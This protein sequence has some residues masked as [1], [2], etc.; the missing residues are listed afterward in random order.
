MTAA[1]FFED[2]PYTPDRFQLLAAEAIESGESVVVTAP[3]GAGKTLVAEVAVFLATQAGGRAFYTTPIKALSNQKY[4]EFG[5][6]YGADNV[7]LLTGDN[8]INGDAPIVVMTTE[9]LR[10]MIYS[11][12]RSLDDLSTVILDEVHYLADRFRGSVWEEVIIHAPPKVQL[13]CLSATVANPEE[14][15]EWIQARRG[16]TRLIIETH[17]PVPLEPM[18][19]V[20]D[21]WA[22]PKNLIYPMFTQKGSVR[23]A[24]EQVRRLL[25]AKTGKRRRFATPRRPDVVDRLRS[26]G[27]LPA[28]YFIFSRAGCESAARLVAGAHLRLTDPEE[29][30]VIRRIATDKTRHL[31]DADLA[32]LEFG[33]WLADLEGGV[34]A[35]HAG[36]VPAFKEVVEELFGMGLIKVVFATETLALG[37]NMPARTVVLDSLSKFN[38]ESHEL[39]GASDYTQLTGRAGRRGI[40]T[41]GYGVTLYSRFTR[42]E[43]MTEIAA[44]GSTRLDSSFRPTYNMAVNLVANYEQERAEELLRASFAEFQLLRIAAAKQQRRNELAEDLAE[45]QTGAECDRGD[46][47]EYVSVLDAGEVR[48]GLLEEIRP[49][50]VLAVKSGGKQGRYLM[51]QRRPQ[52]EAPIVMLSTAGKL[53]QFKVEELAGA[54]RQGRIEVSGAYRPSDRKFQQ[55]LVQRLRGFRQTGEETLA[56]LIDHP[57]AACPDAPTRVRLFRKAAKLDRRLKAGRSGA[58]GLVDQFRAILALLEKKGYVSGWHLLAPGE[59]LRRIYSESDLLVSEALRAGLLEG[60]APAE[61][62]AL[63]SGFVYE[64][65]TEATAPPL[66]R[67]LVER[68]AEVDDLWAALA[69]DEVAAGLHVSRRPDF[70]FAEIAYHWCQSIDLDEIL[71]ETPMAAGDFVRVARQLLD[72]LR[73]IRDAEPALA[74]VTSDAMKLIDR[75]VVAAGGL[76]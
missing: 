30:R 16:P 18:F 11:K 50:D 42:F 34:A 70:G 3:T 55:K 2:L 21:L 32:V 62:A 73:Q 74:A 66:P 33:S 47:A 35:H 29:R 10:N 24:N 57:V 36:M 19:M 71:A 63:V 75:G 23:K 15:T 41:V 61:L 51:L 25:A 76:L 1:A 8:S 26:E 45:A 37:I 13:V 48:G 49:G 38:G 56:G 5:E 72:L 20:T 69:G 43:R 46:I 27:M 12:S 59:R 54:V 39:L 28:I 64:A 60:L 6:I 7:G 4:R 53:R 14:F 9:V 40:D 58:S 17:R 22:K 67:S 44:A 65:R 31:A 68:S 52:A